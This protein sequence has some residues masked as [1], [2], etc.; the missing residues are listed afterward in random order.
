[1]FLWCLGLLRSWAWLLIGNHVNQTGTFWFFVNKENNEFIGL[2][3]S[4]FLTW[5]IWFLDIHSMIIRLERNL[6]PSKIIKRKICSWR[7]LELIIRWYLFNWLS[8]IVIEKLMLISS[9][10]WK[11]TAAWFAFYKSYFPQYEPYET[12]WWM[13]KCCVVNMFMK[14]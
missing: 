1:M 3:H 9:L 12:W 7:N 14:R 6:L 11:D 10:M 13:Q 8:I 4:I 2:R 5:L